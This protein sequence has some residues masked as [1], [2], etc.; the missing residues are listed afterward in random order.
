MTPSI[1]TL[2]LCFIVG[3]S[4]SS[5]AATFTV[6]TT[7]DGDDAVPGN[8]VCETASGNGRCTYRAAVAEASALAGPD[9][10]SVPAGSYVLTLGGYIVASG[11]PITISGAG[12]SATIVDGNGMQRTLVVSGTS[13]TVGNLTFQNGS[14]AADGLGGGCVF[15]NGGTVTIADSAIRGCHGAGGGGGIFVAASTNLTVSRSTISGNTGSSGGGLASGCF[16]TSCPTT[17]VDRSTISENRSTGG[18]GGIISSG[19]L[20]LVNSTVSGNTAA[21]DGGGIL[22]TVLSGSETATLTL[23][24]T[25]VASNVADDDANGSGNGGG[26]STVGRTTLQNSLIADNVDGGSQAPD[27]AGPATVAGGFTTLVED[28]AGATLTGLARSGDAALAPLADNGGPTRTHRPSARGLVQGRGECSEATDQRGVVRVAPCDIGAVELEGCGNGVMEPGEA[29]DDGNAFSTDWCRNDCQPNVCGDGVVFVGWESC[30][31]GWQP[32]GCTDQCVLPGTPVWRSIPPDGGR[33]TAIAVAPSDPTVVYA[34]S[35]VGH[36]HRTTTAGAS[37][38]GSRPRYEFAANQPILALLVDPRNAAVAWMATHYD[39]VYKTTDGGD[40][41]SR[42]TREGALAFALDP[43]QP[44]SFYV[45]T[46]HGIAKTTDGGTTWAYVNGGIT[47]P[48]PTGYAVA[49]DPAH[50]AT[51]YAGTAT[52]VFKTVNGGAAWT[53]ASTGLPA[54]R[55]TKLAVDPANPALLVAVTPTGVF[56]SID[57]AATWTAFGAGLPAGTSIW[58]LAIASA[59]PSVVRAATSDGVFQAATTG[60][61]WVAATTSWTWS[62]AI[63][64]TN[65]AIVYGGTSDGVTRSTDAGGS[66]APATSGLRDLLGPELTI[67]PSHPSTMYLGDGEGRVRKTVDRG[68]TWSTIAALPSPSHLTV[69]PANAAILYA[70]S[71][72]R[73]VRSGDGGVTWASADGGV[74]SGSPSYHVDALAVAATTPSTAWALIRRVGTYG[75][76]YGTLYRTTDGGVSWTTIS[77]VSL[78]DT[79]FLA[80]DPM[81][82]RTIYVA[83]NFM[84]GG[85]GFSFLQKS[86]DGGATWTLLSGGG[87]QMGAI[88]V[89]PTASKVVYAAMPAGIWKST[90]GGTSGSILP[91]SPVSQDAIVVDRTQP[92]TLYTLSYGGILRSLDG[93]VSW[94]SLNA[95]LPNAPG[96]FTGLVVD[97]TDGTNVLVTTASDGVFRLSPPC[98][99]DIVGAGEA[100]DEG[101]ANGAAD[102][103]CTAACTLVAAGTTCRPAAGA[104]DVAEACTGTSATCP[105][106]AVRAGGAACRAAAGICDVGETCTGASP[107]CPPDAFVSAGTVCRTA[108]GVCDVAETCTGTSAACPVDALRAAGRACRPVS[109]ACDLAEACTGTS[110]ACPPDLDYDD[111]GDAVCNDADNCPLEDNPDQRDSDDDGRGDICDPCPAER[112][113]ACNQNQSASRLCDPATLG[114]SPCVLTTPDQR[115]TISVPSQALAGPTSISIAGG[116]QSDFGIGSTPKNLISVVRLEPDD[117]TFDPPVTLTFAWPDAEP[118]PAGDGKVDRTK[119]REKNLKVYR[120]GGVVPGTTACGDQVCTPEACCNTTMNRWSVQ[121][122]HF[123]EWAVGLEPCTEATS[124]KLTLTKVLP[125]AGDDGLVFTGTLVLLGSAPVATQLDVVSAGVVLRLVDGDRVV[126]DAEIPGGPFDAGTKTGWKANAANTRWVWL[127]PKAGAPGGI[128][129]VILQDRSAATPGLVAFSA[130]GK[131]GSYAAGIGVDPALVLPDAGQCFEARFTQ[132][133][134]V[135]PSC[136]AA[137]GRAT[138]K[139]K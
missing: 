25:T 7:A 109:R 138:I 129:K 121:T 2:C 32:G 36:V 39:G 103:C 58:S 23:R 86:V 6:N 79:N 9:T 60:A 131:G 12:V 43:V 67:D 46:Y 33:V 112:T 16:S 71:A 26:V 134:P 126:L 96:Q 69:D 107:A 130:K 97:P 11:S 59:S 123:S 91:N 40:S 21:T 52:G 70:V 78:F 41:W 94:G 20:T 83:A 113:D 77:G 38:R 45:G 51:V 110:V 76:L 4:A 35:D 124:A 73:I 15:S 53:A 62:V 29:C 27:V 135:A 114:A 31:D 17:L 80:L 88:V 22:N 105:A 118:P 115:I 55:V 90:D 101:A 72:N 1:R 30:D 74:A 95:G 85:S 13:A 24:S 99:D 119:I 19:T 120:N 122:A 104:C 92:T 54:G 63:D 44:D 89:D 136:A 42:A 68:A 93:G 100:C 128:G 127:G 3:L 10:V 49:V 61:A 47:D 28:Q 65:P 75:T 106:D 34:G 8:G 108:A 139:C 84:S 64:P 116:T 137:G 81:N 37:W 98:G 82:P 18:G 56:R 48:Y 133:W 5:A 117:V 132:T 87:P 111:D 66:W 14:D 57:A 102:S 125:P 50:P